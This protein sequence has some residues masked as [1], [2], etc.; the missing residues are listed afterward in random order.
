VILGN[1]ASSA[2]AESHTIRRKGEFYALSTKDRHPI[3]GRA[4]LVTDEE[5]KALAAGL[6]PAA[7]AEVAEMMHAERRGVHSLY[8][9]FDKEG[10]LL[11]VGRTNDY[12]RR[13]G[14]HAKSKPW[15]KDVASSTVEH[16]PTFKAL[17][18]AEKRA[19]ETE[20]P[21]ENDHHNRANPRRR[22][23]KKDL[24]VDQRLSTKRIEQQPEETKEPVA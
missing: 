11:Y 20:Y 13:T 16:Y 12:A 7:V 14:E 22:I 5:V 24:R 6:L 2:G 3:H 8:R 21:V 23:R 1:G 18:E 17:S 15:W 19:I 9:H 10:R 4:A